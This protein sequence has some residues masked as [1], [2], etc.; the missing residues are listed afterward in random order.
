MICE[1]DQIALEKTL[2]ELGLRQ[3]DVGVVVHVHSDGRCCEVEFMKGDGDTV[4]VATLLLE[5]LRPL[6]YAC[7]TEAEFFERG[8][9]IA[10]CADAGKPIP[11]QAIFP[12]EVADEK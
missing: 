8:R 11:K 6:S 3:G 7:S 10:Q 5:D 4:G 12:F 1:H 9:H 2:P